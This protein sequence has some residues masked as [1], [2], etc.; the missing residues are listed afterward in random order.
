MNTCKYKTACAKNVAVVVK[1]HNHTNLELMKR[2][3]RKRKKLQK[4]KEEREKKNIGKISV[5]WIKF[6]IFVLHVIFRGE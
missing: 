6:K 4:K 3:T 1:A 2:G 5:N